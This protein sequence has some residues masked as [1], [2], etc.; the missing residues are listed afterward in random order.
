MRLAVFCAMLGWLG[1][2]GCQGDYFQTEVPLERPLMELEQSEFEQLCLKKQEATRQYSLDHYRQY[3]RASAGSIYDCQARLEECNGP[4]FIWPFDPKPCAN[5]ISCSPE[6][7][8]KDYL[9]CWNERFR[10]DSDYVNEVSSGS[11]DELIEKQSIQHPGSGPK[12]EYL[13][14]HCKEGEFSIRSQR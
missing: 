6:I 4:R 9:E 2:S 3:C 1:L 10:R 7:T 14:M 12:C 13:R 8:V 11:C 5:R